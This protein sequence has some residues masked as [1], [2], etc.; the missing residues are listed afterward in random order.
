MLHFVFLESELL[1]R[2]LAATMTQGGWSVLA[3]ARRRLSAYYLQCSLTES[4]LP[5]SRRV[6]LTVWHRPV[7]ASAFA[8]GEGYFG[9]RR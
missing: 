9:G 3:L 8:C 4:E 6:R 1:R 5:G 7:Q 2:A